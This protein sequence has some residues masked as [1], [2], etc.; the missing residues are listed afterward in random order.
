MHGQGAIRPDH[1][2]MYIRWSTEDQGEGTTLS[3]QREGCTH[4]ILSQGW[5]VEQG[6]VFVDEGY[7]GGTLDRPSLARLRQMVAAGLVDCVVVFKLDRLSRS[8]VDTVNLVLREWEGHTHLKSAREPVDTASA[9]GK[10]FFYLLVSYAEWERNVIRERTLSGKLRRA[11]EGR[12]P[13]FRPPFGYTRGPEPGSFERVDAEA[14]LVQRIFDMYLAGQGA[15]SIA[16]HLGADGLRFREGRPFTEST[17]RAILANRLYTGQLVYGQGDTAVVAPVQGAAPLVSTQT[18][19]AA[20]ALRLGRQAAPAP[21]AASSPYLLTGA[22]FCRCGA[23]MVAAAKGRTGSAAYY[24]C[25]AQKRGGKA[26]CQAGFLR[27]DWLDDLVSRQLV[28]RYGGATGRSRYQAELRAWITGAP[29]EA[30]AAATPA[31]ARLATLQRQLQ[32]LQRDYREERLEAGDYQALRAAIDAEL[33]AV[34]AQLSAL[35]ERA[36]LARRA[37]LRATEIASL[38]S[39]LD[40]WHALQPVQRKQV[41]RSLVRRVDAY[42]DGTGAVSVEITWHA[43]QEDGVAGP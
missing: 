26:V 20:A 24:I 11:R 9:M 35:A 33:C 31:R 19:A 29:G 10:Q 15:R 43:G 32:R 39:G 4:Y 38:L 5:Q 28:D 41:L 42:R 16:A 21:R 36:G 1:V 25:G 13:G 37:A 3:V 6:L 40:H 34:Q 30:E 14:A 22:L 12:N 17:V 27:R 8:V 23:G 7:S 2:A 18:F